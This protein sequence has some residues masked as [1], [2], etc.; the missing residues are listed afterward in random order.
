MR[1]S[2]SNFLLFRVEWLKMKR[3]VGDGKTLQLPCEWK[4]WKFNENFE[5]WDWSFS[6]WISLFS[7]MKR[8]SR[9][10]N[11][12]F[13]FDSLRSFVVKTLIFSFCTLFSRFKS[14]FSS[15]R[16][17]YLS[18]SSRLVNFRTIKCCIIRPRLMK[19][20]FDKF[21]MILINFSPFCWFGIL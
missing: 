11:L 9:D 6:H 3:D 12:L 2:E 19:L 21:S 14:K 5:N 8:N 16:R 15:M 1:D 7:S 4:F 18:S 17:R 13:S 10:L 20:K